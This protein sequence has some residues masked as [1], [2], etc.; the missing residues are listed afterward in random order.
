MGESKR[1]LISS[2][3][4]LGDTLMA[5]P[6]LREI[7]RIFGGWHLSVLSRPPLRTIFEACPFIDEVLTEPGNG[8]PR[9]RSAGP[10]T[11]RER[12]DA[13]VLLQNSFRSAWRVWRWGVGE[14][15][16]YRTDGRSW[17]LT[18]SIQ[19]SSDHL[20]RHQVFY[21]L[22]LVSE[23]ERRMHGRS[24]VDFE[25]PDLRL[26]VAGRHRADARSL[27]RRSG[28]PAGETYL[29]LNPGAT[30]SR[31]KQWLP[32]RFAGVANRLFDERGMT[33][34]LVGTA[35]ERPVAD[36]VL[37][38]ALRPVIDLTGRTDLGALM[39]ILSSAS[40]LVTNDTGTS[41]LGAALGVPTITIFGPTEDFA[42]RPFAENAWVVKKPVACAPCMLRDC[43]ID[44]R[45]MTRITVEDIVQA[46]RA[47]PDVACS[48]ALQDV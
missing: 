47:I 31:A 1:L 20:K 28:L 12:F 39:G 8:S 40:V 16:G 14:R 11:K 38:C 27:L 32:E 22:D 21:Y 23:I 13:A 2:P 36:A 35:E 45:C 17:L 3:T 41:H 42:T 46:T 6:A 43:P 48:T 4:W 25:R 10:R 5:V 44:H 24:L 34:V 7:R 37:Q 26:S 33:S 15:I 19:R 18:Q 29:V 9:F 30:N